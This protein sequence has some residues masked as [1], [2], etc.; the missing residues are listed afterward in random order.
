MMEPRNCAFCGDPFTPTK[1]HQIY[2]TEKCRK[3]AYW[4]KHETIGP[5]YADALAW[6]L[7]KLKKHGEELYFLQLQT[8]LSRVKATKQNK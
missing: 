4:S 3:A 8:L 6:A 5:E 2:D 1:K 7:V